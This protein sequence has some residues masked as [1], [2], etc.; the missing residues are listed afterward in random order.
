MNEAVIWKSVAWILGSFLIGSLL[1]NSFSPFEVP[2]QVTTCMA[3]CLFSIAVGY[4]VVSPK[5][6]PVQIAGRDEKKLR[7]Q[8]YAVGVSISILLLLMLIFSDVHDAPSVW[9]L[10]PVILLSPFLVI[11]EF[12]MK[13]RRDRQCT[14][15]KSS[16][17]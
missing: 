15:S 1:L 14:E 11:R 4:S 8:Q 10:F 5:S 7:R 9:G 16:I 13:L 2:V 12:F 6:S 17:E 3:G